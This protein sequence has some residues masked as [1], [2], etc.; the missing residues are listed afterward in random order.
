MKTI[1]KLAAVV[2]VAFATLS[3][4]A[5][6][7]ISLTGGTALTMPVTNLF[8]SGPVE[9]VP[10]VTFTSS[11]NSSVSG[12][13][14]GYGFSS[15]GTWSGAPAMIGLNSGSGTFELAFANAIS[16]FVGDLNWTVGYGPDASISIYDASNVLLE[17]ITLENGLN[18]VDPGFNGFQRAT[19]DISFVRF[20]N[21][22]IGVRSIS[23][24]SAANNVPEPASLALFG[25][26]LAGLVISRRK[27]R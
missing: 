3:S 16:G 9:I 23:T 17:S 24:A 7:V 8:S 10:G 5:S 6:A 13:V 14:G 4:H 2:T 12:Y 1:A 11:V 27:A 21:E 15:N 20:S 25:I 22:Y 26:G 19:N 18:L